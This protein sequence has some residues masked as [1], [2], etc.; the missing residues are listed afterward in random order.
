VFIASIGDF[1]E[2]IKG[3]KKVKFDKL[4]LHIEKIHS[5][6]QLKAL[7]SVNQ[8]LTVRNWMIGHHIYEYEQA[9]QDRAKYGKALMRELAKELSSKGIR[10]MSF[11]NLNTYRQFYLAYPQ[12]GQV[13]SAHLTLPAIVRTPSEQSAKYS[14]EISEMLKH[15][16]FSHFAELIKVDK[17]LARSFYEIQAI[18]GRWSVRELS[19][20]IGSL[21]YERTG[22]SKNKKELLSKIKSDIVSIEDSIRDPYLLEFTGLKEWPEYSENDLETALLNHIQDFLLELGKGFCFESRQK[23]ITLANEHDRIDLVFYHRILKCHVLIDLKNRA[24]S[25]ADA[26]QM[27]FYLNYFKDNEM[28]DGDNPPIGLIL[29]TLKDSVKVKYATGG[30]D[31]KLFVSR[32]MVELPSEKQLEHLIQDDI[33]NLSLKKTT[34]KSVVKKKSE[35]SAKKVGISKKKKGK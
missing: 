14:P 18:K 10:G 9:G 29:C 23:R 16:S 2:K 31:N 32:Y 11:T 8:A 27:N 12:I 7:Q 15:F 5:D 20:Q 13:A 6:L 21:L 17:N 30:M 3:V 4:I 35:A 24:F 25:H 1:K 22:L 34:K 28:E 19:R 26:G 33:E